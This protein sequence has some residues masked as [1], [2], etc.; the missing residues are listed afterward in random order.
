MTIADVVKILNGKL[1]AGDGTSPRA[2]GAVVANDLLNDADDILLITSLA[3]DQA[4]RTAHI[5]GAMGVVVHN[6]KPLSETML[7]VAAD[8]G[9]PLV[10]SP[11]SKYDACVRMHDAFLAEERG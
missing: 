8:L 4:I 3:S 7:K 1:M 10:S 9:V 6:A 11:L 5:V 2:V